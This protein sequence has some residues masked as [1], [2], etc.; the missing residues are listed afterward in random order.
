MGKKRGLSLEEK[1][2]RI[3]QL[4]YDKKE[5]FK[6]PEVE[7][8]AAKKG[9]TMQSVKDVN[10]SLLYDNLIE[11]D[12]IGSSTFFW[13]LP[14]KGYNLKTKCIQKYDEDIERSKKEIEGAKKR[15]EVEK[16]MRED[17]EKEREGKKEEIE[18]VRKENEEIGVKI[19][20]FERTDP[21]KVEEVQKKA[22]VAKDAA[23]RWTDNLFEVQSYIT[24]KNPNITEEDLAK[25]FPILK[26]LDNID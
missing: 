3:L 8:I 19:L 20:G 16:E 4:Y 2:H 12:K 5:A 1:R 24:D 10:N 15:I 7:K 6:L 11:S 9:V 18:R 25:Q 14:S 23:N 13:S 26:D 22:K 17:P 21:K